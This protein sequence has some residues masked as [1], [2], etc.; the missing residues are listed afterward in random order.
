MYLEKS[1]L[2]KKNGRPS[3]LSAD[4]WR[5]VLSCFPFERA[6]T[7][8]LHFGCIETNWL[9]AEHMSGTPSENTWL[10][11][12]N[13]RGLLVRLY[14]YKV[15][16]THLNDII[17]YTV[18]ENMLDMLVFFTTFTFR[19]KFGCVL[20]TKFVPSIDEAARHNYKRVIRY[21]LWKFHAN[22][23]KLLVTPTKVLSTVIKKN[24]LKTLKLL[25]PE[26]STSINYVAVKEACKLGHT[27]VVEYC[28]GYMQ[29]KDVLDDL[30]TTTAKHGHVNLFKLLV[31]EHPIIPLMAYRQAFS[32]GRM[33]ICRIIL[34]QHPDYVP[35]RSDIVEACK[36][37]H[38]EVIRSLAP[39]IELPTD[40]F[41]K[42]VEAA[43]LEMIKFLSER[44]RSLVFGM[45]L[46][47][48]AI[49]S[50]NS[51]VFVTVFD[52]GNYTKL[53][54]GYDVE[55]CRNNMRKA[56]VVLHRIGFPC[57]TEQ[58]FIEACRGC[59]TGILQDM[60]ELPP[61][62]RPHIQ[63]TSWTKGLCAILVSGEPKQSL[64]MEA[65]DYVTQKFNEWKA[66]PELYLCKPDK[67]DRTDK[68][69]KTCQNDQQG[70]KRNAG[71]QQKNTVLRNT[72]PRSNSNRS[73]QNHARSSKRLKHV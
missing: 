24:F 33:D 39:N 71:V 48:K 59:A 7:V 72:I 65:H 28:L 13:S 38:I 37:G 40:C 57:Y 69:E 5:T 22:R 45:S 61:E 26:L 31:G 42:A 47:R 10:T 25:V 8:D 64:K 50:K 35:E 62:K 49:R 58:G 70:V 51:T 55:L 56:L 36:Y 44:M 34:A 32:R 2:E 20:K 16:C 68:R 17:Q 41:E 18:N 12:I 14:K 46:M 6:M 67:P 60:L 23:E 11:A 15:P 66:R 1:P 3:W 43:N 52:K 53:P 21:C 54:P 63:E 9:M 27:D 30:I 19:D 73:G 4:V 29:V